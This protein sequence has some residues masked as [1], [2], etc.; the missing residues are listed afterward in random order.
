[1]LAAVL[2]ALLPAFLPTS[3]PAFPAAFVPTSLPT[4]PPAVSPASFPGTRD[5]AAIDAYRHGDFDT[6]KSLWVA[7][8]ESPAST[9]SKLE[10]KLA[11][12]ERARILYDLGNAAFRKGDTLEA[13]GWY[14]ASLR[15]RP[16]DADTWKNLEHARATAKLEPADRGDLAATLH[17]IVTSLTRAESEWLAIAVALLW[18]GVL[19]GEALRGGRAL[20][21]LA[22]LGTFVT[23]CSLVPLAYHAYRDGRD[24]VLVLDPSERG[25]EVKSEPR[26]D[27]TVVGTVPSGEEVEREDELPGWVKIAQPGGASGWIP[28][29]SAFTLAR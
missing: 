26:P 23:T 24:R 18:G 22:L 3:R 27:A 4:F 8:L 2:L 1:M 6:A 15:L 21:R 17:R 28:A 25:A 7:A 9:D 13:V 10:S 5:Q 12:S 20:R 29:P 16:R 11:G 14:T 19:A